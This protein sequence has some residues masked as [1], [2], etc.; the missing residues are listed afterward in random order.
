MQICV[1]TL[2]MAN[3]YRPAK[4]R[5]EKILQGMYSLAFPKSNK[6]TKAKELKKKTLKVMST[7]SMNTFH[8]TNSFMFS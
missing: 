3:I 7:E 1:T 6:T 8:S 5:R 2:F 4:L